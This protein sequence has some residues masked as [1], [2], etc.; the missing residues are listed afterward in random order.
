MMLIIAA[1]SVGD[2]PRLFRRYRQQTDRS[3]T[4]R[5]PTRRPC[6][7]H[8]EVLL[9]G[10]VVNLIVRHVDLVNDTTLVEVRYVA[11]TPAAVAE[12]S[13]ARSAGRVMTASSRAAAVIDGSCPRSLSTSWSSGPHC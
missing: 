2:H 6:A 8:L 10:R 4:S 13:P 11:A 5:T 3:S 9:D 1:L 12:P 7:A